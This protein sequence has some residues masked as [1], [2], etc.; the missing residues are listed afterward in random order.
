MWWNRNTSGGWFQNTSGGCFC[1]RERTFL[2]S[3]DYKKVTNINE[4]KRIVALKK[5]YFNCLFEGHRAIECESKETC[6]NCN[7]KHPTSIWNKKSSFLLTISSVNL[8]KT[9][10]N[11]LRSSYATKQF[12]SSRHLLLKAIKSN[13][14]WQQRNNT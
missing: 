4:R 13:Q 2:K 3:I 1:L 7:G 10:G 12:N 8:T 9:A 5:S 11:F 6:R 14:W